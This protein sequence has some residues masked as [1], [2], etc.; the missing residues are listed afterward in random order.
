MNGFDKLQTILHVKFCQ[1][2]SLK[3]GQNIHRLFLLITNALLQIA[4]TLSFLSTSYKPKK[5]P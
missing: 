5:H 1:M 4:V 3:I 2:K